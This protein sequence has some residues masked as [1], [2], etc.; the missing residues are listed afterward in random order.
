[1]VLKIFLFFNLNVFQQ[2]EIFVVNKTTRE[3]VESVHLTFFK[4]GRICNTNVTN[5]KGVCVTYFE[6]DSLK[7]SVLGYQ[8]KNMKN[9]A[10]NNILIELSEEVLKI[11]EVVL[12][13]L[14]KTKIIGEW[15]LKGK[16][17][18]RG[19]YTKEVYS[20]LIENDNKENYK[21]I[22]LLVNFKEVPKKAV[23][24]FKFYSIL[25]EHRKC[26]DKKLQ[27]SSI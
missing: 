13:N 19:F 20:I 11:E 14:K 22:S 15:K 7:T 23:V 12:T 10:T 21:P 17:E 1:M 4:N 25:K 3:P 2:K 27:K 9:D 26:F 5:E 8:S 24:A 6:F 18:D 16:K